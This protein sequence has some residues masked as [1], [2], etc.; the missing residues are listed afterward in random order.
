MTVSGVGALQARHALPAEQLAVVAA[1]AL[2]LTAGGAVEELVGACDAL[3]TI[4]NESGLWADLVASPIEQ[5]G[6]SLTLLA[7]DI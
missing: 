3:G 5:V 7:S 1:Q 2:R 6:I 4:D